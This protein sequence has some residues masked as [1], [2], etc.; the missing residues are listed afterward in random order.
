M[1]TGYKV[2]AYQLKKTASSAK[3]QTVR[4]TDQQV[5]AA[6]ELAL[7]QEEGGIGRSARDRRLT[8]VFHPRDEMQRYPQHTGVFHP[9]IVDGVAYIP[10]AQPVSNSQIVEMSDLIPTGNAMS[11]IDD[12]INTVTKTETHEVS[13]VDNPYIDPTRPSLQSVDTSILIKQKAEDGTVRPRWLAAPDTAEDVLSAKDIVSAEDVLVH[14]GSTL[15]LRSTQKPVII[16]E[17]SAEPRSTAQLKAWIGSEMTSTT[18]PSVAEDRQDLRSLAVIATENT[19]SEKI[20]RAVVNEP[21]DTEKINTPKNHQANAVAETPV[22]DAG[23]LVQA[24]ITTSAN[25]FQKVSVMLLSIL[26]V[27]EVLRLLLGK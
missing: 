8:G 9:Q 23:L 21:E 16:P 14:L 20:H 4:V 19:A 26:V 2:M 15:T 6:G 11:L 3:I 10:T 5:D 17:P 27:V 13:F 18:I 25:T 1:G 12:V 22:T 24:G 7:S